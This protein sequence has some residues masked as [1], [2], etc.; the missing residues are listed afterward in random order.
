MSYSRRHQF[1]GKKLPSMASLESLLLQAQAAGSAFVYDE[2]PDDGPPPHFEPRAQQ[3][4]E[5][6]LPYRPRRQ[7]FANRFARA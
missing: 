7:R 6:R 3:R 5:E 2:P 4:V 1:R